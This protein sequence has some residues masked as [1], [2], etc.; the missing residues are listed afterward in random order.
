MSSGV[1]TL[2]MSTKYS[3]EVHASTA[4]LTTSLAV[5]KS[6]I[7]SISTFMIGLQ[8]AYLPSYSTFLHLPHWSAPYQT[9]SLFSYLLP[10][11]QLAAAQDPRGS[12]PGA[13]HV[14]SPSHPP[15]G[16]SCRR[17]W[18]DLY[19]AQEPCRYLF[20]LCSLHSWNASSWHNLQNLKSERG[21]PHYRTSHAHTRQRTGVHLHLTLSSWMITK[22]KFASNH[23]DIAWS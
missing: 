11:V 22:S 20:F 13:C 9:P 23:P 18:A 14:N 7:N 10:Q 4:M 1:S 5:P 2:T 21:S 19:L 16:S 15:R 12:Q 17:F 3:G 6:R 8:L